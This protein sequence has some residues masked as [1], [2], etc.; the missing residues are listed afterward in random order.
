MLPHR[1]AAAEGAERA[2]VGAALQ[3]GVHEALVGTVPELPAA[4]AAEGIAEP[5]LEPGSAASAAAELRRGGEPVAL[6][7]ARAAPREPL[8]RWPRRRR[9]RL[10][11]VARRSYSVIL[12]SDTVKADEIHQYHMTRLVT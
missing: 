11:S 10:C 8:R 9:W 12:M 6:V 5:G 7:Q 4:A 1:P 3:L 2:V